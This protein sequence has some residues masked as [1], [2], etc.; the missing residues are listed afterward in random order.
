MWCVMLIDICKL[1]GKNTLIKAIGLPRYCQNMK[2][3]LSP[4]LAEHDLMIR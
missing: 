2:P 4:Y 3:Y 1:I